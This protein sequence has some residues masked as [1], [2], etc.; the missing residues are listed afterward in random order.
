MVSP[1]IF[2]AFAKRPCE[3]PC[4]GG[5]FQFYAND[6]A[7]AGLRTGSY[8]DGAILA[9]E[10]LEWLPTSTGGAHEGQRRL[11][12][13]MVRDSQRYNSTG[14]WGYGMF[15]EDGKVD[16]LDVKSRE[17][18]YQCHVPRKDQGYVFTE[19]RER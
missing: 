17:A 7:M 16:R 18:C 12:G 5:L 9:E 15:D 11:V 6:K 19:Y 8:P 1:A 2:N 3:K 4:I 10:M 14:G 13:V